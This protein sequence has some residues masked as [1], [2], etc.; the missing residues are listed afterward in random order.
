MSNKIR[1]MITAIGGPTGYGILKCLSQKEDIVVIGVDA[2][3]IT[4]DGVAGPPDDRTED[5]LCGSTGVAVEH[6][7]VI[8]ETYK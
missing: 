1:V 5:P 3:R 2:D 7:T 4:T 8:L 6:R